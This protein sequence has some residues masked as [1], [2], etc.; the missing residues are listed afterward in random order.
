MWA[1]MPIDAVKADWAVALHGFAP[2]T[3][4]L[5][6]EHLKSEGK[7]FPPA[8]PEFVSLCRQFQRRGPHRLSLAAPRAPAPENIFAK[9][10]RDLGQAG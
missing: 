1:G 8:Q 6:L 7:P 3:I 9:L 10:K 2:E 4:R 5:A